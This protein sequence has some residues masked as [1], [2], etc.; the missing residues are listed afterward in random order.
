[1]PAPETPEPRQDPGSTPAPDEQTSPGPSDPQP[2]EQPSEPEPESPEDEDR[3]TFDRAYV[4]NLRS[5]AA[6]YRTA[7]REAEQNVEAL[8]T[9]ATAAESRVAELEAELS[10]ASTRAERV[11]VAAEVGLPLTLAP[12]LIG[13]TRDELVEDARRLLDDVKPVPSFDGGPRD[14]ADAPVNMSD[15]IRRAAG[16]A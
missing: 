3:D 13:A 15:L 1:M 5:E 16:R 6:R 4:E 11:E 8:N 7:A 9:R 10:T 12:R 14:N 2:A